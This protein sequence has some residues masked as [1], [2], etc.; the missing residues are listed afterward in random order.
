MSGDYTV[1]NVCVA[2]FAFTTL[3]FVER[4][5]PFFF[6]CGGQANDAPKL[7]LYPPPQPNVLPKRKIVVEC[8]SLS[9]ISGLKSPSLGSFI[10]A[11]TG[12]N[13]HEL[14]LNGL[15][16]YLNLTK[17]CQPL[18]DVSKVKLQVH[19]VALVTLANQT[20]CPL[21]VLAM[22]A[23]NAGYSVLIYFTN[24][25]YQQTCA[26]TKDKLLIPVMNAGAEQCS[27]L[28]GY[29]PYEADA[30]IFDRTNDFLAEV[31]R[32]NLE[33]RVHVLPLHSDDLSQMQ[34]Y[35]NSLYYWFLV[36]P[37]ITLEWLRRTKKLCWMSGCQLVDQSQAG[38]NETAVESEHRT[39]ESRIKSQ[40]PSDA[41]E[42]IGNHQEREGH[43]GRSETR[44]SEIR[45]INEGEE[46]QLH[47]V[48]DE[49]TESHQEGAGERQP[50]LTCAVSGDHN[51]RPQGSENEVG[52]PK[53]S[54]CIT[55]CIT[56][57]TGF[58]YLF[59]TIAA[60]PVGISLPG[61]GG[62]FFRFDEN[63]NWC[64]IIPILDCVW[65]SPFQIFCFF[66]YSR[67][68]CRE[69]WTVSTNVSK[70]IR[71]DW[72]ASNIYLLVL[73]IVVPY[74]F[75]SSVGYRNQYAL[76]SV[77]TIFYYV[78]FNTMC[79][80]C[81]VLFI[82][83]LNKHKFVTRYVFYIS[84][85]MICAYIESDVVAVYY[86]ALN[87]QGSLNDLKLTALRT[88]AIGLT[89][90]ISFS[91]SMHII[92]KLTMPRESLFEGLGVPLR[93]EFWYSIFLHFRT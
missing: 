21:Q 93:P 36:G 71:S 81:N 67:F 51:R 6:I 41:E 73:G 29:A 72:F 57:F 77:N 68:A 9:E 37:I 5:S 80:V 66:M 43:A 47:S 11:L 2:F 60:L 56:C 52:Q 92:R 69:T 75:L 79:T 48:V 25:T 14:R 89:L 55:G 86:F 35:L 16:V 45:T 91:S 90:T 17:A 87:S 88:V 49:T 30:G 32:T 84:V 58:C 19:K 63:G 7:T 85:C 42:T 24:V 28:P 26:P 15:A 82:I 74:C 1:I 34:T 54:I 44:G 76:H 65:W 23:Q 78:A 13:D 70:L 22:N 20:A 27:Y 53:C 8:A 64:G 18:Q 46:L 10:Q 62:S 4:F 39:R 3:V 50:L 38:R 31:D 61:S 59:L 33:I 12:D 83:I 40:H